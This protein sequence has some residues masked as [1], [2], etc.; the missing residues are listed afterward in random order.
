MQKAGL[1][2]R[3]SE[4]KLQ[5]EQ[6]ADGA[7]KNGQISTRR[8]EDSRTAVIPDMEQR[9]PRGLEVHLST[10]QGQGHVVPL[11]TVA[12]PGSGTVRDE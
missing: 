8:N 12:P 2:A 5:A 4:D 10:P 9:E 7:L 11:F 1:L 3:V 6:R